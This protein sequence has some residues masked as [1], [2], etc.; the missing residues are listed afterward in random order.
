MYIISWSA[1]IFFA[2][3]T[4]VFAEDIDLDKLARPERA[5]LAA[6]MSDSLTV[7]EKHHLGLSLFGLGDLF[8]AACGAETERVKSAVNYQLKDELYKKLVPGQ[9]IFAMVEKASELYEKNHFLF[10]LVLAA[11]STNIARAL[12]GGCQR[13]LSCVK[14]RLILKIKPSSSAKT[15]K[16]R[17]EAL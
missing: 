6:C 15:L 8:E 7:I 14:N 12:C 10:A 17:H 16:A 1:L 5:K 2:S 4:G 9:I 3:M 13:Q 11:A